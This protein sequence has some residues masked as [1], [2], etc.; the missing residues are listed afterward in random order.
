MT[1]GARLT[2]PQCYTDCIM[3]AAPEILASAEPRPSLRERKKLATRRALRRAALDLVAERGF[4]HVTVEDIAEAA[5]V[6][7]R[8]FFN[9]S[10]TKEAAL[11]GAAAGRT[12]ALRLRLFQQSP[13]ET[14]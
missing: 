2:A 5:A 9:Y 8:A 10:R 7:P 6:S 1:A 13:G 12:E 11:S 3:I 4:A 14:G